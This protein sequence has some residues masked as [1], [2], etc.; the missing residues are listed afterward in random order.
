LIE[1]GEPGRVDAI[2]AA[3]RVDAH[4][5][6]FGVAQY[7]QV[8]RNGRWGEG[9]VLNDLA[10]GELALSQKLDDLAAGGVGKG[11]EGEH[12]FVIIAHALK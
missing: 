6:Q 10:G 5:N 4:G 11:G 1:I 9:E 7:F 12:E 3:L 8:L 2:D